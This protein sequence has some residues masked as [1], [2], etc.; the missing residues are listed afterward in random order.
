MLPLHDPSLPPP[1]WPPPDFTE[2]TAGASALRQAAEAGT[3]LA[4][5]RGKHLA[6]ICTDAGCAGAQA[7]TLAAERLGARVSRLQPDASLLADTPSAVGARMLGRLYDGV[8]FGEL[9]PEAASRLQRSAGVPV[10]RVTPLDAPSSSAADAG[11][12]D[13]YLLQAWLLNALRV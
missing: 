4:P 13:V 7:F 6:L 3:P 1:A 5:L 12:G 11:L 2:V 8:A 10:L 9:T